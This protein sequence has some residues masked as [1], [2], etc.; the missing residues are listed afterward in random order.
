MRAVR[1]KTRSL[2]SNDP[3]EEPL[4][5]KNVW[6]FNGHPLAQTQDRVEPDHQHDSTSYQVTAMPVFYKSRLYV[7][8][9][10]EAFHGMKLGWLVCLDAAKHGD[11][12]RKGIVWKYDAIKSTVSTPAIADGLVY[13]ADFAGVLHCLDADTGRC[14]WTHNVGG[15]IWG[16]PLAADGKVYLGTGRN[17]LWVFKAGKQKEVINSIRTRDG[18]FSTPVA[19]NGVLYVMTNKHLYAV[20]K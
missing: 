6:K 17:T 16:S 19:A 1:D 5:L 14:Y 18:I 8:L 11:I 15:P 12:T 3:K 2:P 13:A 20:G 9:T 4:L 10:Q 7:P